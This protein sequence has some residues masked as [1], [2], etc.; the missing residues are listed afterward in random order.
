MKVQILPSKLSGT[1]PAIASKSDAHRALICSA[2]ADKVCRVNL[3]TTSID[4]ETTAK[5][6]QKLGAKITREGYSFIVKPINKAGIGV[7]NDIVLDCCESGS[8]LRF[9]MPVA[10]SICESVTFVGSGRL[11][12][13]P[14]TEMCN[15]LRTKG[16]VVSANNLPISVQKRLRGGEFLFPGNVSSQYI[17]GMLFALPLLQKGGSIRVTTPLE[18]KGYVDI[19]LNALAQFG[20]FPTKTQDGYAVEAGSAHYES[21]GEYIVEGDW[22]NAA[23]WLCANCMGA[24]INVTG[25]NDFSAQGD[26]AVLSVLAQFQSEDDVTIDARSI[27]DLVPILAITACSRRAPTTFTGCARLRLKESD[28]IQAV[29][30]MIASLGG[31][32]ESSDD[33]IT[34]FGTGTLQGGTVNGVNDH[35][36]VMS[37]TI[38][39]LICTNPVEITDAQA[40]QKSYPKFFKDFELLGGKGNVLSVR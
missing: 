26:R 23:F 31:K 3:S 13:R 32:A 17:S 19:T 2:L 12:L 6:L 5:V 18:S 4:I 27:P 33:S 15:A 34:V 21:P 36:I 38:A 30:A 14:M 39:S 16:C 1:I 37:A 40:V 11:P 8:T 25:L 29:C 24:D 22:S 7:K 10:T 20:V 9:I 28:R 35:R